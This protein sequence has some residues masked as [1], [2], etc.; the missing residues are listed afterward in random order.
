M[1]G[2][3]GSA[4]DKLTQAMTA[5]YIVKSFQPRVA[6]YSRRGKNGCVVWIGARVA[7]YGLLRV[8]PGNVYVHRALFVLKNGAPPVSMDLD[9][10]CRNRSC[11][12]VSHLEAVS[13]LVNVRRGMVGTAEVNAKVSRANRGRGVGR[14][15]ATDTKSKISVSVQEWW[16]KRKAKG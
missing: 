14:K 9:H 8:E 10:L 2:Q 6:K 15:L 1:R 7:G 11:I 16:H 13:R 5:A 4:T 3:P 12:N